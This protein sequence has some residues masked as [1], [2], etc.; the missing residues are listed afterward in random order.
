[1]EGIFKKFHLTR[2]LSSRCGC[3][4][5]KTYSAYC[6]VL[7]LLRPT[8]DVIKLFGSVIYNLAECSSWN[9]SLLTGYR[10]R[11]LTK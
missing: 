11:S 6:V 2:V 1:M 8:S 10:C 4:T 5:V 7:L 3:S 9:P